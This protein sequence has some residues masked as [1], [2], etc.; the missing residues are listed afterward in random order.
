M[1]DSITVEKL[2]H[3]F[4]SASQNKACEMDLLRGDSSF[5]PTRNHAWKMADKK[6]WGK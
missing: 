4:F 6:K 2:A 3:G 1:N 5:S